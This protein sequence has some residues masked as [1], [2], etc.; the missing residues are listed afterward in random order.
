MRIGSIGRIGNI[1]GELVALSYFGRDDRI[2]G[3]GR[4]GRN[5]RIGDMA[6][7][8]DIVEFLEFVDI[9]ILGEL[10]DLL[11]MEEKMVHDFY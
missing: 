2:W 10:V 3:Y 4:I 5:G 8:M 1:L 9:V 6:E 7:L 11:E